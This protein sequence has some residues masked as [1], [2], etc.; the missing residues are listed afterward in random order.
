MIED[1]LVTDL[2]LGTA[3]LLVAQ[4]IELQRLLDAARDLDLKGYALRSARGI[5]LLVEANPGRI[6]RFQSKVG[7]LDSA[8]LPEGGRYPNLPPLKVMD[9]VERRSAVGGNIDVF[10]SAGYLAGWAL[11]RQSYEELQVLVDEEDAGHVIAN[12]FREDLLKA[13]IGFGAHSFRWRPPSRFLDGKQ[14]KI[15]VRADGLLLERVVLLPVHIASEKTWVGAPAHSRVLWSSADESDFAA[16]R[17]EIVFGDYSKGTQMAREL[18]ERNSAAVFHDFGIQE[19]YLAIGERMPSFR[20]RLDARWGLLYDAQFC[21][22]GTDCCKTAALPYNPP[23]AKQRL[24]DRLRQGVTWQQDALFEQCPRPIRH[25]ASKELTR[26]Y[27]A[28]HGIP[29]ARHLAKISAP[30][31]LGRVHEQ[32]ERFVLKPDF[33]SGSRG[34]FLMHSGVNLINRRHYER[35]DLEREIEKYLEGR[36]QA[37]FSVEE[38]LVQ[39]GV[40]AEMPVVPLDYKLHC[41]GGKTRIVQVVDRNPPSRLTPPNRQVWYSRDWIVSPYRIR[42]AEE[43]SAGVKRPE[44]FQQMLEI[45]DKIS[46]DLG[47]YIRVDMYATNAGAVLGELTSFSNSGIGFTEVASLLLSQAWELFPPQVAVQR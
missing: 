22:L 29:V 33:E 40:S 7:P 2:T 12:V 14:H 38:F 39:E 30:S 26:Q 42:V 3:K 15:V 10:T 45:A 1:A 27:A 28:R 4:E 32:T 9:D 13:G 31:D 47:D 17:D 44:C 21:Q 20:D 18:V 5:L 36:P 8:L 37:S 34:V 46:A 25:L 11:T 16:A 41:F 6:A 24:F 35:A 23:K 43:L 19:R